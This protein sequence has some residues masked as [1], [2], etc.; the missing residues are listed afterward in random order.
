MKKGNVMVA[1]AMITALSL[2]FGLYQK[3]RADKLEKLNY[4]CSELANRLKAEVDL[5][6][7]IA[8]MEKE[9]SICKQAN[10]DILSSKFE[11]PIQ[12]KEK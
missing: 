10:G 3:Y 8:V 1:L 12:V 2:T 5:I 11:E 6:T 9:K 4:E 7:A